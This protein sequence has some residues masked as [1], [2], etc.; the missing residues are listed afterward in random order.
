M[1]NDCSELLECIRHLLEKDKGSMHNVAL[2]AGMSYYSLYDFVKTCQGTQILKAEKILD[3][4]G[5]ELVL[6]KK[7]EDEK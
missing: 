6:R 4:L 7:K 3:V 5:Y 1:G 2:K